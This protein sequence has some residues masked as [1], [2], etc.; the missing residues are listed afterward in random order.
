MNNRHMFVFRMFS[1]QLCVIM[2]GRAGV[3]QSRC[4]TV[5]SAVLQ[6]DGSTPALRNASMLTAHRK[7]HLRRQVTLWIKAVMLMCCMSLIVC[8]QRFIYIQWL[9]TG[10]KFISQLEIYRYN[11][12][13]ATIH[14]VAATLGPTQ[15]NS[16]TAININI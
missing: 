16:S 12:S 13:I 10:V 8:M 11:E 7:Q 6:T 4:R 14:H 1:L 15:T 5:L 9:P 3:M 2:S